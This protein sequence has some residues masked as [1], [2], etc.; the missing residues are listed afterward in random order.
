MTLAFGVGL[1][2]L[3]GSFEGRLHDLVCLGIATCVYVAHGLGRVALNSLWETADEVVDIGL[4]LERVDRLPSHHDGEECLI[5]LFGQ[6]R[7]NGASTQH[8]VVE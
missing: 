8:G 7:A 6:G 1:V 2:F 4:S 5:L 3:V